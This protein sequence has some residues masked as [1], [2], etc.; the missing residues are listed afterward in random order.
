MSPL[1]IA[2]IVVLVLIFLGMDIFTSFLASA[3]V[4]NYMIGTDLT[5]FTLTF[6]ATNNQ[7]AL[8]AV[9][10]FMVGGTIMER[11]GIAG[12]LVNWC[13]VILAYS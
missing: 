12:S 9:P 10:L 4:Y 6:F 1:L 2:F 7:Y 3:V 8:L 11:S 13:E 5:S